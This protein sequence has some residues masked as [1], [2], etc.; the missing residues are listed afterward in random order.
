MA[1]CT[2]ADIEALLP[3]YTIDATSQP[4]STQVGIM[5]DDIAAEI[6]VIL[7]AQGYTTPVTEPAALLTY[8]GR[9]NALGAGAQA[10]KAM[11]PETVEAGISPIADWL[12]DR[13]TDALKHLRA[14]ELPSTLSKDEDAVDAESWY[15]SDEWADDYEEFPTPFARKSEEDFKF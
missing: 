5:I 10:A 6:D 2:E 11:F 7:S 1:Y 14:G 8:L 4:T 12:W 15:T 13:Y 3:K 9:V